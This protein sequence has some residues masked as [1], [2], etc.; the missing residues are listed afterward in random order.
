MQNPVLNSAALAACGSLC[1]VGAIALVVYGS[2]TKRWFTVKATIVRREL[3]AITID[4]RS[5]KYK[6]IKRESAY[7]KNIFYDYSVGKKSFRGRS[8]YVYGFSPFGG[9][10][11]KKFLEERGGCEEGREIQIFVDSRHPDRA[12]IVNGIPFEMVATLLLIGF[13]S[14][15]FLAF[16]TAFMTEHVDAAVNG[17]LVGI[18]LGCLMFSFLFIKSRSEER[19]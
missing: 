18:V 19:T 14:V 17:F 5:L 3:T 15:T 6:L 10:R 7:I 12:V 4:D 8:I 13:V 2:A 16:P 9:G 11:T 1:T